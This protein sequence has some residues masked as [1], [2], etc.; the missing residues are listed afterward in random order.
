MQ[1]TSF[2][3]LVYVIPFPARSL[4][5][6]SSLSLYRSI[7]LHSFLSFVIAFGF[8]FDCPISPHTSHPHGK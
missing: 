3:A 2:L 1:A 7:S 6:S 4:S 5:L 8:A